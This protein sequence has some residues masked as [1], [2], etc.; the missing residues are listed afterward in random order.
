MAAWWPSSSLPRS[1]GVGSLWRLPVHAPGPGRQHAQRPGPRGPPDCGREPRAQGPDRPDHHLLGQR[2]PGAGHH[3]P[4]EG[5]GDEHSALA[6][7][8]HAQRLHG[9][10]VHQRLRLQQPHLSRLRAGRSALPHDG[11][12]SAQLLR[13]LRLRPDGSARQPG[14]GG[15]KLRPAGHHPLQPLPRGGNRRLA[16]A[17]LQLRPGTCGHGE[18]GQARR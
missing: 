6:D 14:H 16:R 1:Q 5:Q 8:H 11:Q 4:R 18:A 12:R 13:A 3:R 2:S 15:R 7:H 17:R 10:G 9:L